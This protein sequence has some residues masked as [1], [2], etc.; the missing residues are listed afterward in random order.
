MTADELRRLADEL[1][2]DVVGAAPAAPYEETERHIRDR[3][4]RGLFGSMRFTMAQPE[5]SCHPETLLDGA[6]TVV[7]AA[8]CYYEPGPSPGPG[9][10]ASPAMRGVTTTR[11]SASASTR[12]GGGSAVPTGCW[13]TPTST[14]TAPE[15]SARASASS[16]RT[17]CSSPGRTGRGSCSARS[18]PTSRSSRPLRSTQAVAA[19]RS[20]ST[21][22]RR[23]RFDG[24]ARGARRHALPLVLDADGGD[25][26]GGR[27]GCARRPC[28][29]LRH[30][31]G[32][33]PVE[34]RRRE[35]ARRSLPARTTRSPSCRWPT[36]SSRAA[37]GST[38]PRAAVRSAQRPAVASTE[39]PRRARQRRRHEDVPLAAALLDDP[40]PVLRAVAGAQRPG[41]GSAAEGRG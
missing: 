19:A 9:E 30:L 18:S 4:A 38:R 5:V 21:R 41:S 22:A 36:G 26:P 16:A 10:A 40:D 15:P 6:R 33:L 17:R 27:H 34:P 2:L 20:A 24:G 32:R 39:R 3:R 37:T 14:S 11:C 8:L 1:G 35:T 28:L 12:S 23:T 7:S 29:R 31:P 13:W 25:D